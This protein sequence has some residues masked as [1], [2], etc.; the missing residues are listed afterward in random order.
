M[1]F[2]SITRE[3]L[4]ASRSVD[5]A[6]A[7]ETRESGDHLARLYVPIHLKEVRLQSGKGG[8]VMLT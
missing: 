1:M 7:P 6:A 3:K 4:T 5:E 2:G 8:P